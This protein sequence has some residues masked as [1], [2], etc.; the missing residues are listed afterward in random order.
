MEE[1]IKILEE[2]VNEL[3]TRL[4]KDLW[5]TLLEDI[6]VEYIREYYPYASSYDTDL[7]CR[8]LESMKEQIKTLL[9]GGNH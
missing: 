5:R 4:S 8:V 1:Q 2:R 3:E 7:Y 9:M 6:V